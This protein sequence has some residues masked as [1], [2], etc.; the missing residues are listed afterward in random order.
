M[1]ETPKYVGRT[2][3][4]P[5]IRLPTGD[6]QNIKWYVRHSRILPA[7]KQPV[8]SG[9]HFR[10]VKKGASRKEYGLLASPS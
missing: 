10:N 2:T 9:L 4:F 5:V 8:A 6:Y 1:L 3:I 7:N